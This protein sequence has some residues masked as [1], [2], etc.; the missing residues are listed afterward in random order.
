MGVQ[1]VSSK[2]WYATTPNRNRWEDPERDRKQKM[3]LRTTTSKIEALRDQYNL[4]LNLCDHRLSP[5]LSSILPWQR[6]TKNARRPRTYVMVPWLALSVLS[7][8]SRC[9][10]IQTY[11]HCKRT[12]PTQV[13]HKM[14][15]IHRIT[16]M[17]LELLTQPMW[18]SGPISPRWKRSHDRLKTNGGLSSMILQHKTPM[19]RM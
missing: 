8:S 14:A 10:T 2:A 4:R 5:N 13:T 7:D 3:V 11:P 17:S 18:H 15:L 1:D 6:C 16:T 12:T 9:K 19:I